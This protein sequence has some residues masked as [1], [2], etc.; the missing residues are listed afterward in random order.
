MFVPRA[1]RSEDHWHYELSTARKP[2]PGHASFLESELLRKKKKKPRH[3]FTNNP[4]DDDD[5][6]GDGNKDDDD[7]G[8]GAFGASDDNDWENEGP[9]CRIV[10]GVAL[11][12]NHADLMNFNAL[13]EEMGVGFV[14]F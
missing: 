7:E 6:Y 11:A 9:E 10:D 5:I 8:L 13:V 2:E 14:H 3:G 12:K 1:N 4:Y